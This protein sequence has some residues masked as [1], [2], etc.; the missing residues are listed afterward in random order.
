MLIIK[1]DT[2]TEATLTASNVAEDEHPLWAAGTYN[3]GD[4]VIFNHKVWEAVS[5][6]TTQPDEGSVL[7]PPEWLFVS[8]TNRFAMFDVTVG[9]ATANTGTVDVTITPAAPYNALVLFGVK[10]ATAQLIVK[11]NGG[12]TVYDKT[13][14]LADYSNITGLYSYFFGELPLGEQSEVAFLD[15]PLYSGATYQLIIDNGA[16]IAE[17]GE[18]AF[19]VASQLAVTNFGTSVGIKDYSRKD[20]DQFGN[21]S[22]VER[23]FAKRA[24]YDLTVETAQVGI[25]SRF[26]ANI[27]GIPAVYIGDANR[28]ETIVFGF[29]KDFSVQLSNPSISSCT[30]T[31]EGLT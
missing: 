9:N 5:T 7:N 4:R 30:L 1:P 19:G 26:L 21:V 29:F 2:I 15:I 11:D 17:C 22:I 10:G 13:V 24:D 6:T 8:A 28:S 16:G 20:V 31:V 12:I 25:F 18:A 23:A 27:R 14:E 3:A